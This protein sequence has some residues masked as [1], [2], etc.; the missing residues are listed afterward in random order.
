MKLE[1]QKTLVLSTAPITETESQLLAGLVDATWDPERIPLTVYDHLSYG[2]NIFTRQTPNLDIL[3]NIR[4]LISLAV[5]NGCDWLRFDQDGEI[6]PDLPTF[7]WG[8]KAPIE[9]CNESLLKGV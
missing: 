6:V 2:W 5:D 7:D 9:P 4:N 8:D 3:P 1:I